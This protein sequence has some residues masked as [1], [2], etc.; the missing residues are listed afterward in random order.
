MP[1][2]RIVSVSPEL[3]ELSIL[4]AQVAS[5]RLTLPSRPLVYFFI[6]D[7]EHGT[8]P[9]ESRCDGFMDYPDRPAAFV[10]SGLTP[11]RTVSIIFH[12]TFHIAEFIR[13][14]KTPIAFSELNAA[15][16]ARSAPFGDIGTLIETLSDE[17]ELFVQCSGNVTTMQRTRERRRIAAR[18]QDAWLERERRRAR[19][20]DADADDDDEI[21]AL[22]VKRKQI[23]PLLM[24]KASNVLQAAYEEHQEA[25]EY[26]ER[27]NRNMAAYQARQSPILRLSGRSVTQVKAVGRVII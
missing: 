18:E 16:F 12:E 19:Y 9:R 3:R 15:R 27:F 8:F 24:A 13:K 14:D 2:H 20:A 5:Q 1:K 11:A 6:E 22:P 4:A 10:R 7:N 25:A 17:I 21:E 26:A 23:D